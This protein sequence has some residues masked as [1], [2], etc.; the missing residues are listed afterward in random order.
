M[1][2]IRVATEGFR[3]DQSR[4]A[5]ATVAR[6]SDSAPGG[7]WN[8]WRCT[9]TAVLAFGAVACESQN[10]EWDNFAVGPREAQQR[11]LAFPDRNNAYIERVA[12]IGSATGS[13]DQQ[14]GSVGGAAFGA[15][16]SVYIADRF[17]RR[18]AHYDID[19][20]L[21][22]HFG[23]KGAG[24]GEFLSPAQ[25]AVHES[26]V[27]VLDQSLGRIVVF[28]T[29]GRYLRSVSAP[30]GMM[31]G[32]IAILRPQLM[33]I[34]LSQQAGPP[35][36][37]LDSSG[38]RTAAGLR[39]IPK[40][41][42]FLPNSAHPGGKLCTV[43]ADHLIYAN[44]WIYE[45]VAFGP[46]GAVA[47][48]QRLLSELRKPAWVRHEADESQKAASG[49]QQNT[50]L[51]GLACGDMGIVVAYLQLQDREIYYDILDSRGEPRAHLMY[52]L[53]DDLDQ[54]GFLTDML[55][56]LLLTYRGTP[57]PH[58][59]VSRVVEEGT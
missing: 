36:V 30:E 8:T 47:W 21:I 26:E 32:D 15:D 54:P 42:T 19:G 49:L 4:Q 13:G 50:G 51:M 12:M 35:L 33:A 57:Y 39:T 59:T 40:D 6:R 45:L 11:A 29:A 41:E 9:V 46:E 28:D 27:A 17:E 56:D 44:P 24:P 37:L 38:G 2:R 34:T 16:T 7:A 5:P 58:V 1:K 18:I 10:T 14:L 31:I 52:P 55:G 3:K 20:S 22:R 48:S 23:Q 25:I 53:S 43:G